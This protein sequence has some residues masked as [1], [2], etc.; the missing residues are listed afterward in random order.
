MNVTATSH[1]TC[2]Y[3]VRVGD[4]CTHYN[5]ETGEGTTF[6]VLSFLPSVSNA[7]ITMDTTIGAITALAGVIV[8]VFDAFDLSDA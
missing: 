3:D 8:E 7:V 1:F 5:A 2:L 4:L 6:E